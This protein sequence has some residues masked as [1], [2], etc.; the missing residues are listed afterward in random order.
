MEMGV[1]IEELQ[2][3]QHDLDLAADSGALENQQPLVR[4]LKIEILN[5]MKTVGEHMRQLH[6]LIA[7]ML[8]KESNNS[9]SQTSML[10]RAIGSA[11]LVEQVD[12]MVTVALGDKPLLRP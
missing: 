8:T 2:R 3:A 6:W 12:A 10:P 1:L 7:Q 9:A 11:S 4:V 5:Q